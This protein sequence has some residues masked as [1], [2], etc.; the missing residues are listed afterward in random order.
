[1]EVRCHVFNSGFFI[2]FMNKISYSEKLKD[3]RWQK[4]RLSI[5]SRDHFKC[6]MCGDKETTLNVHHLSYNGNP[7]EQENDKL[8]TLCRHCHQI[9]SSFKEWNINDNVNQILSIHKATNDGEKTICIELNNCFLISHYE[10]LND[11]KM[12]FFV[13]DKCFI[14]KLCVIKK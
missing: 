7:W 6:R 4:K 5:M 8:L 13:L 3:P 14:D 12:S 2:F 11:L 9:V 1:M 10:K